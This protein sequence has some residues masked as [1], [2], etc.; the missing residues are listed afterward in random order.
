MAQVRV[1][2]EQLR[3]GDLPP[4]CVKTGAPA[5]GTSA[6]RFEH[7]PPWTYLL[8]LAGVLPF[9]IA[10]FF[11]RI[12]LRGHLPATSAVIERYH[13]LGR[14]RWLGVGAAVAGPVTAAVAQEPWL[15]TLTLA[16]VA[17]LLIIEARRAA[18]WVT[19]RPVEGGATV[20]LRRVHPRFVEAVAEA[21]TRA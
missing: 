3:T 2:A 17:W 6:V 8:L 20:E 7:L 11:A 5:D 15:L 14:H 4:V 18:A 21:R 13:D 9:L 10:W 12:Q 1:G 19:A 16:G